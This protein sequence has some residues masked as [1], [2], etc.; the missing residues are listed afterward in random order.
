MITL[1]MIMNNNI[2]Y[3]NL[4]ADFPLGGSSSLL[5]SRLKLKF[6]KLILAE[7]TNHLL[8]LHIIYIWC[9]V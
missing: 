4:V 5:F 7:K 6:G 2:N 9:Q 8:N 3:G 1:I